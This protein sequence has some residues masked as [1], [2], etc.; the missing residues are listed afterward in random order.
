MLRY[1]PTS[2][3]IRAALLA[4]LLIA[5]ASLSARAWY[6]VD[7]NW[8][9]SN[10]FSEVF[11][12]E[13]QSA[14]QE[15]GSSQSVV[16]LTAMLT[17][18]TQPQEQREL[19]L[20]LAMIYC[21][22]IG[23][24][25]HPKAIEHFGNALRFNLPPTITVG[26]YLLRG[27][28]YESIHQNNNALEDYLRGL[29]VC[30]RYDLPATLAR[31]PAVGKYDIVGSL[32]EADIKRA[33]EQHEREMEHRQRVMFEREMFMKQYKDLID[34][35]KLAFKSDP[36]QFHTAAVSV[37]KDEDQIKKLMELVSSRNKRP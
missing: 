23:L 2:I 14:Q 20:T 12:Q 34:A 35:A 17:K 13:Y 21:Q 25:D 22:R 5:T 9:G 15:S 6:S 8:S 26:V 11:T 3:T 32:A 18:Y 37:M 19:E 16:R 31:P 4:F 7:Y 36:D 27:N 1:H 30:L 33:E 28:S 24:V 10:P 29:A